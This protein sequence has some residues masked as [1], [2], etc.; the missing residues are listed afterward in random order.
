[1]NNVSGILML[2]G[3]FNSIATTK[4]MNKTRKLAGTR[5]SKDKQ[6]NRALLEVVHDRA[7][8]RDLEPVI[9]EFQFVTKR[10]YIPVMVQQGR[11][12]WIIEMNGFVFVG[13]HRNSE[14]VKYVK[15]RWLTSDSI[16]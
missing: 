8:S 10:Y 5:F 1:M 4:S 9:N 2:E 16:E 3:S 7:D 15:V 12:V 13:L 11:L 6:T 14:L